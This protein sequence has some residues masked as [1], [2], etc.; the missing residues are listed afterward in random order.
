MARLTAVVLVAVVVASTAGV[1]HADTRGSPDL[2]VHLPDNRV[3]PGE[4]TTLDVYLQNAGDIDV[5]G[6]ANSESRVTTARDVRVTLEAAGAPLSVE[7]ATRP[8]GSVPE[9]LAG[10]VSFAVSVDESAAP[11]RYALPVTVAYTYTSRIDEDDPDGPTHSQSS[12]TVETTVELVV[13]DRARFAVADARADVAVGGAGTVEL[14]VRHDGTEAVE[15]AT[16]TVRSEDPALAFGGGTSAAT[17][18]GAWAPGESRTLSLSATVA[19]G[20]DA[21]PLPLAVTVDFRDD[22]GERHQSE[23]V[24]TGV[25][26][27]AEQAFAV[28]D[29]ESTLAVGDEG[30][31]RGTVT[32]AGATTV[33]NAVVVFSAENA[34]VVPVET[35][36]AVGDLGPGESTT[37]SFDAEVS[38]SAAAGPR[39]LSLAVRYRDAGDDVRRSG[40]HDVRVGVGPRRP[41]FDVE[42]VGEPL[43]A[44]TSGRLELRVTNAG[45]EA[46]SAVSAKL[47][48]DDPLASSDDEAFVARL[49]PGETT[50]MRFEL[51]AAADALEKVYPLSLDFQY[52]DEDGDTRLS[53]TYDVPVDVTANG[54]AGLPPVALLAAAVAVLALVGGVWYLR[55]R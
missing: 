12:G 13:E 35:E 42:R 25:T 30:T 41:V 52:E 27:D 21:R 43:A 44:G 45:D 8:V 50:V 26:P 10:P 16:V 1:A 39:Q 55:R 28:S 37:F 33:R 14:R 7:T 46:V 23:P 6:P 18:V 34:N 17:F 15:D 51:S 36:H 47:F 9:G 48:A 3:V 20:I 53:N 24:T 54:D 38:D 49:E 4:R 22:D 31:L 5:G 11:G 40:P 19:D 29:V 32:N 2:S